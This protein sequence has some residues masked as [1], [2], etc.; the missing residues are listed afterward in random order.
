MEQPA[1]QGFQPISNPL[2]GPLG[3][4][5]G[6]LPDTRMAMLD[7]FMVTVLRVFPHKGRG[8]FLA[9]MGWWW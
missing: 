5:R 8:K 4:P 1:G 6:T 2:V 9:Q 7:I 3:S